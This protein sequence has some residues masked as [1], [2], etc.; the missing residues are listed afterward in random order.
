[1]IKIEIPLEPDFPYTADAV[2]IQDVIIRH[3]YDINLKDAA[4]LW[5]RYSDSM[6]AGWM[7]LPD[8]DAEIWGCVSLDILDL[9]GV[10]F[11]PYTEPEEL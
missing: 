11:P 7:M 4:E 10:P 5:H 1:M 2:R 3:G 8:T 6:A 9:T